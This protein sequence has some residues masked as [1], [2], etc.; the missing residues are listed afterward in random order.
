MIQKVI[1][2][3]IVAFSTI[4]PSSQTNFEY[5]LLNSMLKEYVFRRFLVLCWFCIATA[6]LN[7]NIKLLLRTGS[8]IYPKPLFQL[9]QKDFYDPAKVYFMRINNKPSFKLWDA[10]DFD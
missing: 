6:D 7:V 2:A 1:G 5:C 3:R 10:E 8:K 9:K 4:L